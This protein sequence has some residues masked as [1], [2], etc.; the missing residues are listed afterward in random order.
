[1]SDTYTLIL[2]SALATYGVRSG[3]YL[4]MAY[5]GTVNHRIEAGLN[6]VPIAVLSALVAP[7]VLTGHWL[8]AAAIGLVCLL[9]LRLSMLPAIA[10]AVLAL[11]VMRQVI[12]I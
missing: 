2:L 12:G 7:A 3:G 6:A 10:L 1:M 11:A 8:D 4:L 5:F 9:S